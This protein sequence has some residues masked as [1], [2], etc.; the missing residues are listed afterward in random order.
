MTVSKAAACARP[1]ETTTRPTWSGWTAFRSA[2]TSAAGGRPASAVTPRR[3][4]QKSTAGPPRPHP[5]AAAMPAPPDTRVQELHLPLPPAPKPMAKYRP[6]VRAGNM[7]YV[8]GHGPL[9]PDGTLTK[10][11]VGADLTAEQ[12]YQAAR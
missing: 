6:A 11:R 4:G 8:S 10:G 3:P 1:V 5:G 2:R 12:G 7:L 9:H